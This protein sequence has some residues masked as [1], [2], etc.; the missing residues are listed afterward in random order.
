MPDHQRVVNEVRLIL[1]SGDQT[2]NDR[3]RDV[4]GQFAAVCLSSANRLQRCEDY[5]F[6]GRRSESVHLA[7]AQPQLLDVL[8]LINFPERA[9]WD[10]LAAM[11]SLPSCPTVD[12]ARAAVV[13]KTFAELQPLQTLLREHRRLS[14]RRAPPAQRLAVLRQLYQ[15]DNANPIWATQ[16]E[17]LESI[18]ID[19]LKPELNQAIRK[20]EMDTALGIW[21]ELTETPW[22]KAP[23]ELIESCQSSMVFFQQQ[24]ARVNLQL[25]CTQLQQAMRGRDV[26]AAQDLRTRWEQDAAIANLSASDPLTVAVAKPLEWL[27]DMEVLL[28]NLNK[29]DLEAEDLEYQYHLMDRWQKF[30]PLNL[31][32]RYEERVRSMTHAVL[33]RDR[34]ILVAVLAGCGIV[35]ILLIIW[36]AY[37]F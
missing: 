30:L 12:M 10:E 6:Q 25:L 7:T 1:R 16:I 4:A 15:R 23:T 34:I 5:A 35:A 19:E 32:A 2:L 13:N 21:Q 33:S 24:K 37:V 14:L 29:Q 9:Q 8:A 27:S 31:E 18:R 11:Y 22:L 3:L 26:M 17:Q 20:S 36:L 28:S